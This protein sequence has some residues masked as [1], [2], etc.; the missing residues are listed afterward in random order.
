LIWCS[1]SGDRQLTPAIFRWCEVFLIWDY[2]DRL[3]DVNNTLP[4]IHLLDSTMI[5]VTRGITTRFRNKST[6]TAMVEATTEDSSTMLTEML[7]P[8]RI[9]SSNF[10]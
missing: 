4:F 5:S 6:G 9:S 7:T 8:R 2:V 1:T 10:F 3:T